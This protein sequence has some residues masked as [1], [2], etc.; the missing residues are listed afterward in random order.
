MRRVLLGDLIA[1]ARCIAGAAP[2][3][4]A[5]LAA[6]LIAEADAAHRYAK[7]LGR[8]H[9]QWGMGSLEARAQALPFGQAIGFDLGD[10]RLLSALAVLAQALVRRKGSLALPPKPPI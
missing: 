2:P 5:R 1:A 3:D 9:P 8:P 10:I 7:R 6:R 4:R